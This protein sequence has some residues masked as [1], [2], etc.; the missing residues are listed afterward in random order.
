[1]QGS[2]G[3]FKK[4]VTGNGGPVRNQVERKTITL[5][6]R[7][8]E[9]LTPSRLTLTFC[10]AIA[11][12]GNVACSTTSYINQEYTDAETF[13]SGMLEIVKQHSIE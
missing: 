5:P 8:K 1:M 2:R 7:M 4:I 12:F 13:S 10:C 9:L 6:A 3:F 11:L